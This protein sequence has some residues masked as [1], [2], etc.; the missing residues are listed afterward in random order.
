MFEVAGDRIEV[1]AIL[2]QVEQVGAHGH[3]FAGPA[4]R[5]VEAAEQLL[6]PRL[7]GEVQTAAGTADAAAPEFDRALHLVSVRTEGAGQ[8]LE[9]RD[10]IG[11]VERVIGVEHVAG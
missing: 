5:A 4:G 3:Q 6:S 1:L 2:A 10:A 7:G 9:E 11:V 8:R